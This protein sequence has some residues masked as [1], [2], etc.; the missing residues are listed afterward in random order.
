MKS[1]PQARVDL[2]SVDL[3]SEILIYDERNDAVHLLNATAR[4]IWQLC[5]GA[6]EVSDIVD[7]IGRLFPHVGATQVSD[8]VQRTLEQ[9]TEKKI[10]VLAADEVTEG[11]AGSRPD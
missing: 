6:H 2:R 4:R 1:F 8:D 3:G 10:I 7:E 5:D 11:D 9:L